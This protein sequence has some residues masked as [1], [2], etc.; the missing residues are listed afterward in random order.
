M[1]QQHPTSNTEA[2]Q[3]LVESGD[4][5]KTP[6]DFLNSVIGQNVVVKLN[7]GVNYRGTYVATC[8]IRKL[9]LSDFFFRIVY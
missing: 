6:T 3:A 7:S 1:E 8:Q 5:K 9:Q 2:D 4:S